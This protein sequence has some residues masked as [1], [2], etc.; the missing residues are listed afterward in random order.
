MNE[1]SLMPGQFSR[2][3][4]FR[5]LSLACA[6]LTAIPQPSSAWTHG[7]ATGFNGGKSQVNFNFL[8]PP[9]GEFPYLDLMK[10]AQAWAPTAG[11]DP[12][13][14]DMLDADGWPISMG[15]AGSFSTLVSTGAVT[16]P[17]NLA[18]TW[19]GNGTVFF[20]AAVTV[21]PTLSI[22][23]SISGTTMDV[24]ATSGTI[25]KG[26]QVVGAAANT[27]VGDQLSGSAGGTGTYRVSVSQTLGSGSL[28]LSG[29]SLT[30]S[31]GSG[32]YV[33]STAA[34]SVDLRINALPVSNL[35]FFHVDDEDRLNAGEIFGVKFKERIRTAKLGAIRYLNYLVNNTTNMSTWSTRKPRGYFSYA[36][37]ELRSD[38]Y[39]G[40]TTGTN[41][42]VT[43]NRPA[44]H[45][46]DGTTWNSGDQP[47]HSDTVHVVF[48]SSAA[49]A[50]C[51]MDIGTTGTAINILSRAANPL[52]AAS[53]PVGGQPISLATMVYDAT[54]NAWIKQGGGAPGG[55]W[56]AVARGLEN[57][58][59]VEDVLQLAVEVG[60]HPQIN[61]PVLSLTPMTDY[62]PSIAAYFRDNAPAWM[63]PKFEPPNELWN[64][65][66][67]EFFQTGYAAAIATAYGWTTGDYNQWYGKAASTMGQAIAAAYG[68]AQ[69]DVKTQSKYDA[70]AAVQTALATSPGNMANAD[71]RLTASSYVN[72]VGGMQS[73]PQAGYT[74]S[75]A[76]DW[77]TRLDVATYFG[78]SWY[79]DPNIEPAL[80]AAFSGKAFA[81]S[82]TN[83][84]MTV[85]AI[86]AS[87]STSIA[88]GDI[89]FDTPRFVTNALPAG[90]T[91][92]SLG[93]GSGGVGT[94]NLS[95]PVSFAQQNVTAAATMVG[96]E[97]YIAANEQPYSPITFIVGTPGQMEWINHPL[98]VGDPLSI[99]LTYP[100][101]TGA[102]GV[103]TSTRYFVESIVSADLVTL[104]TSVG[105]PAVNISGAGSGYVAFKGYNPYNLDGLLFFAGQWQKWADSFGIKKLGVYEGGYSPD[106]ASAGNSQTD[107]FRGAGLGVSALGP[108][109]TRMLS[110]F[111]G[112]TAGDL[113][114]E[115]PSNYLLG[116]A[117]SRGYII[118]AWSILNDVYQT[119]DSPQYDSV[120]TFNANWLLKRDLDPASNDNSPMFLE[121]AA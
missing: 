48:G 99:K 84:V 28:S 93:T 87:S 22:T 50:P 77:T 57:G 9:N 11:T 7:K 35:R 42:Y 43:A 107:L 88:I 5:I 53:Y 46:S 119:P 17:G 68:I 117:I 94:Y 8:Y 67:T 72:N 52:G 51:T 32:R 21:L 16:R 83:G 79:G 3:N 100:T 75:A 2:R 78:S 45:S 34:G 63:R 40:F 6:L 90:V 25:T 41:S 95:S 109:N 104:A 55:G 31:G 89:I 91:V 39:A 118:G 80:V 103:S 81:A 106:F 44:I 18:I 29:G 69:A 62:V 1:R 110:E 33:F 64:N 10:T 54:L 114:A 111:V 71:G 86:N 112:L 58:I 98:S 70:V 102:S 12:V 73:P 121:K 108:L 47:K 19:T 76:S 85:T 113:T 97:N 92:A 14:P 82:A 56:D 61:M 74:L 49:A 20:N 24:T 115:F 27:I 101:G 65:R 66:P 96:A 120:K 59:P 13:L 36:A 4:R 37:H 105:G 116:A 38:L 23:A 26:Y 30:G 60:A 15:S